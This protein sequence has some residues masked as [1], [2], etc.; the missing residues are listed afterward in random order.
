MVPCLCDVE[1]CKIMEWFGKEENFRII[2]FQPPRSTQLGWQEAADLP[3][4]PFPDL[5]VLSWRWS[6]RPSSSSFQCSSWSPM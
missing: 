1:L 2:W 6:P 5:Q 4:P 3:V